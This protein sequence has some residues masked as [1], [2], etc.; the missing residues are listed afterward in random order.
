[1]IIPTFSGNQIVNKDGTPTPEFKQWV[2][3][4]VLVLQTNAGTEGL[5]PSNLPSDDINTIESSSTKQNGTF[6]YDDDTH[7]MKVN[8]NGTFK[9]IQ[10]A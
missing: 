6:I 9:T 5:T 4:L 1:M 3:Q 10:T 8:L 7:E 2:D